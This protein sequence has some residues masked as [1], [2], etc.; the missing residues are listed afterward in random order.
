MPIASWLWCIDWPS[1]T[2]SFQSK[3]KGRARPSGRP[4]K[5]QKTDNALRPMK[6]KIARASSLSFFVALG[7]GWERNSAGYM[8]GRKRVSK[9]HDTAKIR[10][11]G[12]VP[13]GKSCSM[14]GTSLLRAVAYRQVPFVEHDRQTAQ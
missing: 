12:A 4:A 8:E 1:R 10:A 6:A 11:C 14:D 3:P 7:V 5:Y 13:R 2:G 9:V